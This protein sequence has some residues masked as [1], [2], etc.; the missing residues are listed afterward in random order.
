MFTF[1]TMKHTIKLIV[2]LAIIASCKKEDEKIKSGKVTFYQYDYRTTGP[3]LFVDGKFIG[4]INPVTQVPGCGAIIE[5]SVYTID[6]QYGSHEFWIENGS[7]N[8]FKQSYNV[9]QDC[10]LVKVRFN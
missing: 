9:S 3:T 5:D 8:K 1:K 4:V 2:C 7:G 10:Q 6:L